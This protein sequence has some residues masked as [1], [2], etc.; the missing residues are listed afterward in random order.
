MSEIAE[1]SWLPL[2]PGADNSPII[3]EL[4]RPGGSLLAQPGLKNSYY[5]NPINRD[6][7]FH[8]NLE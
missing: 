3:A 2:K 5:G 1:L 7:E 4:K 6:G 8:R